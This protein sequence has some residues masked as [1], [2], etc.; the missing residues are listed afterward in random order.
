[1]SIQ[2][3]SVVLP[4]DRLADMGLDYD[5]AVASNLLAIWAVAW[6]PRLIAT[7]GAIPAIRSVGSLLEMTDIASELLLVPSLTWADDVTT[8]RDNL[9]VDQQPFVPLL[10]EITDRDEAWQIIEQNAGD[11]LVGRSLPDGLVAEF[12]ALGFAYF[13]IEMLTRV[14][15]YQSVAEESRIVASVVAAANK[16]LD[17]EPIDDD[18]AAA[19]DALT[20]CRNHYYPVDFYL[21]DVTLATE[22]VV[23]E[24]LT[25]ALAESHQR[26]LL[27]T[28][29]LAEH[30]ATMHP[31]TAAAIKSAVADGRLE[32][33]GGSQTG[34]DLSR[35]G[36]EEL[37]ADLIVARESIA[38]LAA[39][40]R[41]FANFDGVV[42]PLVPKLAEG[43]GYHGVL[44]TNFAGHVLPPLY[45]PRCRWQGLDGTRVEALVVSPLD[46]TDVGTMLRFSEL[47][48]QA[49]DNDLVATLVLAG[50]PGEMAP[51]F[52]DLKVIAR[53][54]EVLGR[55]V[56]LNDYF[57]TTTSVDRIESLATSYYRGSPARQPAAK[58][59]A[60][61]LGLFALASATSKPVE[62]SEWARLLG[63]ETTDAASA[64][65]WLYINASPNARSGFGSHC[66]LKPVE[67]WGFSWQPSPTPQPP[68]PIVEGLLLRN[69]LLELELS[70]TSSG[71][72]SLR[73]YS[74]R[75]TQLSQKLVLLGGDEFQIA[76]DGHAIVESVPSTG[77]IESQ[78][79]VVD[80]TGK[81]QLSITQ[82]CRVI[83]N[84]AEVQLSWSIQQIENPL[85]SSLRLASRVAWR[86]QTAGVNWECQDISLPVQQAKIA[87]TSWIHVD[88]RPAA[89]TLSTSI[90]C[91]HR[92]VGLNWLDTFVPVESISS[93][94]FSLRLAMQR[95]LPADARQFACI[96]TVG[97]PTQQAGWWLHVSSPSVALTHIEPLGDYRFLIRLLETSGEQR[98]CRLDTW[99]GIAEARI[100]DHCGNDTETLA[101]EAGTARL[102][103]AGYEFA[104][105][106]LKLAVVN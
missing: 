56:K 35:F 34:G 52:D 102:Q 96:P 8:W 43:L 89:L 32:V 68:L 106:A 36:A 10:T 16:A 44:M 22:S 57:T 9:P 67:P 37:L 62:A 74:A 14:M 2:R 24:S 38:Q 17:G 97:K 61:E 39:A 58:S 30:I 80:R 5:H 21:V 23:G 41:S 64:D 100:V 79:R 69:E 78:M 55:F 99:S 33:I 20:Q 76:F 98:Q 18:L 19:Y 11:R 60:S 84:S 94:P 15:S 7:T 12:Y 101:I 31:S 54:S 65:G 73:L 104:Q 85:P 103:L 47:L 105:I 25:R 26:N 95:T 59:N 49:M 75:G 4:T 93:E 66:V 13:Q 92:R 71:I 42:A 81:V 70:E 40:P 87:A 1:M 63:L 90:P 50:W 48:S 83:R 51:H 77:C 6:H 27:L 82:T 53:R 88:T 46:R 29:E 28:G 86:D 45:P 3:A 72:A 91:E